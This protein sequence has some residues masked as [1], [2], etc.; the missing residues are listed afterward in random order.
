MNVCVC[1]AAFLACKGNLLKMI[2]ISYIWVPILC[3]AS[4]AIAPVM[5]NLAIEAGTTLAA[6]QIT[7]WGMDIAEIRWALFEAGRGN[8]LGMV[9]VGAIGVLSIFYFKA[10]KHE[11]KEAKIRLGLDKEETKTSLGLEANK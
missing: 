4:T 11:E 8:V 7:W 1:A 10:M 9:A 2:I 5:T 6:G 3:W